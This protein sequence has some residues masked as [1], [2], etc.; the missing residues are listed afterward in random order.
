MRSANETAFPPSGEL[1]TG[2][3]EHPSG[4]HDFFDFLPEGAATLRFTRLD[5][6]TGEP[7]IEDAPKEY[8]ITQHIATPQPFRL[9]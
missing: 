5:P 4:C 1:V 7:L 9:A 8:R 2:P 6:R 3:T